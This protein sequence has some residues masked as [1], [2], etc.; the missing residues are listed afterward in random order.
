MSRNRAC[1]P[2]CS[3]LP[4][5]EQ[6][7]AGELFHYRVLP[8]EGRFRVC[9]ESTHYRAQRPPARRLRRFLRI[10]NANISTGH[11]NFP[12]FCRSAS[13]ANLAA[14]PNPHY[15][16]RFTLFNSHRSQHPK[17]PPQKN[18]P[19]CEKSGLEAGVVR[20]GIAHRRLLAI[21]FDLLVGNSHSGGRLVGSDK[22]SASVVC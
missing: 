7:R 10:L 6:L 13:S 20:G 21:G 14:F 18:H 8:S 19:G 16:R 22:T 5:H 15:P 2:R 11:G 12:C 9:D 4:P 17:H 1:P 3:W